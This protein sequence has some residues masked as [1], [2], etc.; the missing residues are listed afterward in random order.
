VLETRAE[1]RRG[2]APWGRCSRRGGGGARS[3]ATH[4]PPARSAS[5]RSRAA[6]SAC[7]VAAMTGLCPPA[8][9]APAPGAST[10]RC[11]WR[12]V[13]GREGA[14]SEGV[15]GWERD[16]ERE[17]CTWTLELK[18]AARTALGSSGTCTGLARGCCGVAGERE[19]VMLVQEAQSPHRAQEE[20][21]ARLKTLASRSLAVLRCCL[22]RSPCTHAG[23]LDL[24]RR[25][26][27]MTCPPVAELPAPLRGPS[28]AD[29]SLLVVLCRTWVLMAKRPQTSRSTAP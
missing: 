3:A 21:R 1:L 13:C 20:Q 26:S 16:E 19:A 24:V 7:A 8:A 28:L 5:T 12:S 17:A 11:G 27:Y 29:P 10:S 25:A 2:A 9:A 15:R 18:L 14:R 22:R 6:S 23:R 4:A